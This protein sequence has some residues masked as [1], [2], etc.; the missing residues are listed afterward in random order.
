[1]RRYDAAQDYRV[2]PPGYV[3]D[4]RIHV[5]PFADVRVRDVLVAGRAAM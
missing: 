4:A 1:M 2:S 5:A 3:W